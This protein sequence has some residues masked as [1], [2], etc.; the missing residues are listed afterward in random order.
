MDGK[1]FQVTG[2]QVSQIAS[3]SETTDFTKFYVCNKFVERSIIYNLTP[4]TFTS[5]M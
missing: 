5:D 4:I 2:F 3:N 1:V